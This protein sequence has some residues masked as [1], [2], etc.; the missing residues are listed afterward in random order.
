MSQRGHATA[1]AHESIRAQLREQNSPARIRDRPCVQRGCQDSWAFG[2]LSSRGACPSPKS[3]MRDHPPAPHGGA[4]PRA[5]LAI[6]GLA[7]WD[8]VEACRKS[9]AHGPVPGARNWHFELPRDVEDTACPL[10]SKL[11]RGA[12]PRSA[13]PTLW[14]LFQKYCGFFSLLS[15]YSVFRAARATCGCCTLP[16]SSSWQGCRA[17]VASELESST[18]SNIV[19]RSRTP[20]LAAA[21][22]GAAPRCSRSPAVTAGAWACCAARQAPSA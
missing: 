22:G 14:R 7:A 6:A 5:H 3:S 13:S 9:A 11:Y 19:L 8:C 21:A 15:W 16:G 17:A 4:L 10:E 12:C 18:C 1:G 2:G 20:L